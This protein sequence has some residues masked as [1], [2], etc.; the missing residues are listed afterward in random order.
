[1]DDVW[2]TDEDNIDVEEEE[3]DFSAQT[4][5]TSSEVETSEANTDTRE[6]TCMSIITIESTLPLL[7]TMALL[8]WNL[9][10]LVHIQMY[11]YQIAAIF[12]KTFL[13]LSSP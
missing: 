13:N 1:M 3:A 4:T 7:R 8:Q 5:C 9:N 10:H 12:S 11:I 6:S 2:E